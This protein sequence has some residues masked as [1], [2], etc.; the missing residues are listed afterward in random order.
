[1][2]DKK[3][4]KYIHQRPPNFRKVIFLRGSDL[5]TFV[6]NWAKQAIQNFKEHKA[7]HKNK[8]VDITEARILVVDDNE[9]NRKLMTTL[10]KYWGCRHELAAD[11]IEALSLMKEASKIGDP[12]RI[13]LLDQEMPDMDGMELGRL[14]KANKILKET[15]IVMVTSLARR[16]DTAILDQIGFA[17]YLP[18]PVR[19]NQLLGCLELVL[20]RSMDDCNETGL[21]GIITR[22]TVAESGHQGV[23]ILLAEDNVIN[24]KV[25]QHMLKSLGYKTDLVADGAEAIRALEMIDYDLVLMDCMMPNIDGFEATVSIR[26]CSSRVINYNVPIIAMTANATSEDRNKCLQAG[27]NAYMSKPI[28]KEDLAELLDKLLFQDVKMNFVEPVKKRSKF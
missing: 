13:A 10:L 4:L 17:G 8:S 27:M 18:K 5:F 24:Q 6:L 19:Q 16:G 14:I 12:F 15:L 3:V 28:K 23:R 21:Q 20:A 9:T 2:S 25:A 22:H 7:I 26:E 11:G 1:M